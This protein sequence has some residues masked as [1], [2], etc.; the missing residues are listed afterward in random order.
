MKIRSSPE[1]S[2]PGLDRGIQLAKVRYAASGFISA[3]RHGDLVERQRL[4]IVADDAGA[5]LALA[6]RALEDDQVR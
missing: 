2:S 4:D 6:F 3:P 1:H 5:P